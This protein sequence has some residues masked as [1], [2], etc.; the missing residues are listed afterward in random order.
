MIVEV[1]SGELTSF[2]KFRIRSMREPY[3]AFG[4][5]LSFNGK[6]YTFRVSNY[7]SPDELR[8]T[9]AVPSVSESYSKFYIL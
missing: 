6:F 3:K 2:N 8:K 7:Y 4:L 1:T 9:Y 5:A